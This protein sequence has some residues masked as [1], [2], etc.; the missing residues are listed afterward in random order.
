M[1]LFLGDSGDTILNSHRRSLSSATGATGSSSSTFGARGLGDEALSLSK[2][3]RRL[4][5]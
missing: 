2:E 3:R 4:R 5:R 1:I